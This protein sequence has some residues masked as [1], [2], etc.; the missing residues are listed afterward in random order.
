MKD[1]DFFKD[2]LSEDSWLIK[3]KNWERSLQGVRESLFTLGNGYLGSR[4]I[5]E[6][7]PY[8]SNRGTYIA[9]LYDKAGA[10][11]TELANLPNPINFKIIV[12]GE[13]I[14]AVAMDVLSHQRILDMK[15]GLLS[16]RTLF[17]NA[18]K[19]KFDYQ[20]L[21]FFSKDNPHLGVMRVYFTALDEPVEIL[22]E[23]SIDSAVTNKG[24]L[25][26]G[27]KEHFEITKLT[28]FKNINYLCVETFESKVS[29]AYASLLKVKKGQRSFDTFEKSFHL[30]VNKGETVCFTKIFSIHSSRDGGNLEKKTV[31]SLRRG[32]VSGFDGLFKKHIKAWEKNWNF[33]DIFL[34]PDKDTQRFLRFNIYHMLICGNEFNERVSIGARTLSG[35]GYRGHIFWDTEI[36]ILPFFIHTN[37]GVAKNMLLYRYHTLNAARMNAK[38]ANYKGALFAW[39][40]ADDGFEV[41]PKWHRDLDGR[42]IRIHTGEME[43][44]VVADIAYAVY[45]YYVST[46]DHEFMREAGL[47]MFFETA[48]FWA[49]RGEFN[50]DKTA[51]HIHH[52]IG[53]DEFHAN[54]TDNAYT[55]VLAKFNLTK[56]ARFYRQHK[57]RPRRFFRRLTK[58]ISLTET[59]IKN[60]EDI[61]SK[62]VIPKSKKNGLIESF[63]G[64]F[65]KKYVPIKA[66][67]E[68]FM[69]LFPKTVPLKD[70]GRTQLIKQADVVMLLHLFPEEYPL[71]QKKENF[72][73]YDRRTLHKSSLSPSTYAAVGWETENYQKA[74]HYFRYAL[75]ADLKNHYGNTQEGIHAASLGG[76]WQAVIN[77]FAGM[78]LNEDMISF[79]PYLPPGIELMKFKLRYKGGYFSISLHRKSFEILP[80]FKAKSE[81]TVKV[82][83]DVYMLS[84]NKKYV[85]KESRRDE[86][87]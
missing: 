70:I 51:Y 42:M 38:V 20:S 64:Y 35:E 52:I 17:A 19:Q 83:G 73:F 54:V 39:E 11:V 82:Y 36:F 69:P 49:S 46:R 3:E 9:G 76:I 22:V 37:P 31:K 86:L 79:S 44:H 2:L 26:E 14:D 75:C 7:I 24:I 21:R 40:S 68:N 56:A 61:A 18:R 6:E 74:W 15:K 84:N 43:D 8:D 1:K 29:V 41:T 77:G 62:I 47:E 60:W 23:S 16:R 72:S 85:F 10:Q 12:Q 80:C 65:Q 4:G 53:P 45:H 5:L 63:K 55:N 87:C 13:K 71:K 81:I 25:S 48:R 59:E 58:K 33:A 30:R 78:R 32:L 67:D 28:N 27:R 66:L 34:K 57:A 50:R